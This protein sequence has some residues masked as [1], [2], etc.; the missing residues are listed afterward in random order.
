MANFEHTYHHAK[1]VKNIELAKLDAL[2]ESKKE[3]LATTKALLDEKDRTIA[4]LTLAIGSLSEKEK[5]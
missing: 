4:T 1:E 3:I 2:I 5:K